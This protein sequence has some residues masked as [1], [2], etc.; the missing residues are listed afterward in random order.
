MT[1]ETKD[2]Y[3]LG[4]APPLG[5]VPARML[6][7]TIRRERFGPPKDAFQREVVP[8]PGI[9]PREVL[10]YVMAAGINFNNV[11]AALGIP[12]D[13]IKVHAQQGDDSGFH[14]GGIPRASSAP[15]IRQVDTAATAIWRQL[16]LLMST[17]ASGKHK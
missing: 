13:V 11:W 1:V 5:H 12:V 14:I 2:L 10:V 6:A 3:E 9:G 15:G 7:M 8:T 17:A 16:S 4:E